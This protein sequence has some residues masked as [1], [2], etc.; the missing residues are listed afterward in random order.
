MFEWVC[1]KCD[2]TVLAE[3]KECPH[4]AA[5]EAQAAETPAG[6]RAVRFRI[7]FAWAD[8]ERGF[9]FGLGFLAALAV[10][11]FVLFGVAWAWDNADWMDRLTRWLRTR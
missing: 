6:K 2:R 8:V 7:T 1:P 4:C 9:R 11:Y 10:G 5:A 3:L